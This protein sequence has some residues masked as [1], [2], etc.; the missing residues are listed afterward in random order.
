[1][2]IPISS[3]CSSVQEVEDQGLE[4]NMKISTSIIIKKS[5]IQEWRVLRESTKTS[6]IFVVK[7]KIK[8]GERVLIM[9]TLQLMTIACLDTD[10]I[11]EDGTFWAC[12]TIFGQLYTIHGNVKRS[13]KARP[14][15][16]CLLT[17]KKSEI[18]TI[19]M[20]RF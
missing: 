1:M 9:T 19:W 10:F 2:F 11:M 5:V 7:D 6:S 18:A 4:W 16:F 3:Q 8:D 13:L 20:F 14:L 12:P 15:I 17:S